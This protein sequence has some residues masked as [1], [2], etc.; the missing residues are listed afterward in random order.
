MLGNEMMST[1]LKHPVPIHRNIFLSLSLSLYIYIYIYIVIH[2]QTVSLYYNYSVWLDTQNA[3]SWD[4]ILTDVKSAKISRLHNIIL[5]YD[6]L[7]GIGYETFC[8][9]SYGVEFICM[10][11]HQK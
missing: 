10:F 1:F 6:Y 8:H 9:T 3:S 4:R 11:I 2:R 5:S 7:K